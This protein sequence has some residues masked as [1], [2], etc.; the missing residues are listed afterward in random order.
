MRF[1]LLRIGNAYLKWKACQQVV[2]GLRGQAETMHPKKIARKHSDAVDEERRA[3]LNLAIRSAIAAGVVFVPGAAYLIG[4]TNNR[5]VAPPATERPASL[6]DAE[7]INAL[8][9]FFASRQNQMR[10]DI[11]PGN[12]EAAPWAGVAFRNGWRIEDLEMIEKVAAEKLASS[13]VADPMLRLVFVPYN[14]VGFIG[15][16]D[17]Q[18]LSEKPHV[19][20]FISSKVARLTE[21]EWRSIFDHELIHT[22]LDKTDEIIDK[23]YLGNR[24][25]KKRQSINFYR[26]AD[27]L[28]RGGEKEKFNRLVQTYISLTTKEGLPPDAAVAHIGALL[29]AEIFAD[30]LINPI[31]DIVRTR[32]QKV[33]NHII[34]TQDTL[35]ASHVGRIETLARLLG[36]TLNIAEA[37][38]KMVGNPSFRE[39]AGSL[40]EILFGLRDQLV[41]RFVYDPSKG[42]YTIG[43]QITLS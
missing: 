4:K 19:A 18:S 15:T 11:E 23:V 28:I 43:P 37:E 21:A 5:P 3:F 33:N 34:T 13:P 29:V 14:I 24:F 40:S 30:I 22:L 32:Y 25:N 31:N 20:L 35:T 12:L 38:R 7:Q 8:T 39:I 27:H 41:G 10:N 6:F 26:I 1:D 2:A 42:L 17:P 36:V 9:R 16:S